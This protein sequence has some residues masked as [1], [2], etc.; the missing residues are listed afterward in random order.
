LVK[1]SIENGKLMATPVRNSGSGDWVHLAIADAFLS[2]PPD[3]N[4]FQK[5]DYYPLTFMQSKNL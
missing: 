3:Q 2:L 1:T 5:G 4:I